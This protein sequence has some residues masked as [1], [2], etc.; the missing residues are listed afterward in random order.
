MNVLYP[1]YIQEHDHVIQK[2]NILF[3]FLLRGLLYI[4][5]AIAS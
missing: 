5:E 2:A 3:P 4:K 1:N